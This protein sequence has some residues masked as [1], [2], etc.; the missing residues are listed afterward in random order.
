MAIHGL[1]WPLIA[2]NFWKNRIF[3]YRMAF[4]QFN[5]SL[6][7][8]C[9][10]DLK[11]VNCFGSSLEARLTSME[12]TIFNQIKPNMMYIF[13]TFR[14]RTMHL[15]THH[16]HS[17]TLVASN[18][19]KF[20]TLGSTTNFISFQGNLGL[21]SKEASNSLKISGLHFLD[22]F[23]SFCCH[24]FK[25]DFWNGLHIAWGPPKGIF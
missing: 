19:L 11:M 22:I 9:L 17:W 3:M 16:G 15:L 21:P 5:S 4:S 18:G 14:K 12:T 13:E 7:K 24:F 10:G 25:F 1:G 6:D 20:A 8:V 2:S 23:F